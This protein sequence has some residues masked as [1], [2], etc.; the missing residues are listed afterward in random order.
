M[1]TPSPDAAPSESTQIAA[2]ASACV[3]QPQEPSATFATDAGFRSSYYALV[4]AIAASDA[5]FAFDLEG[6]PGA[7]RAVRGALP[8]MEVELFEVI[9]EDLACE[10]AATQEALYQVVRAATSRDARSEA[11]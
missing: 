9:L 1:L 10:L 11:P 8:A 6:R 7:L 2:L 5:R 4:S 3:R